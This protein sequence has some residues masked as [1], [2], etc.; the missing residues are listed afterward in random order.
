MY[1]EMVASKGLPA[2]FHEEAL[3]LSQYLQSF[4]KD[5]RD[6]II[7][8]ALAKTMLFME[9]LSSAGYEPSLVE[10]FL[11][12]KTLSVLKGA[13]EISDREILRQLGAK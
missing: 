6:R 5:A 9:E 11:I 10:G 12:L 8:A 4:E 3:R 2:S 13:G 1:K 7:L